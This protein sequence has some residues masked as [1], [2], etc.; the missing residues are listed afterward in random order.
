MGRSR[1][2]DFCSLVGVTPTSREAII[3]AQKT[4]KM[5]CKVGG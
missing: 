5:F 1:S 3:E 2:N 4:W